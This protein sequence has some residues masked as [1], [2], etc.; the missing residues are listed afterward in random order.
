MTDLEVAPI[1]F[2]TW[3]LGGEW[4]EFD[5]DEANAAIRRARDLGINLFDTAFGYG[6]GASE[7]VL[8]EALRDDLDK[9]R[10]S[11]AGVP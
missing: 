11:G 4:G 6:F 8:G 3:Q 5:H 2:G 10:P 1:A 7:K 9:R